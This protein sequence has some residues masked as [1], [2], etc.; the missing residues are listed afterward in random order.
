MGFRFR[1]GIV[2][3]S[4]LMLYSSASFAKGWGKTEKKL[5]QTANTEAQ[6]LLKASKEEVDWCTEDRNGLIQRRA[7]TLKE[8]GAFVDKMRDDEKL[9]YKKTRA[10]FSELR[11]RLTLCRSTILLRQVAITSL[12]IREKDPLEAGKGLQEAL[13]EWK[14]AGGEQIEKVVANSCVQVTKSLLAMDVPIDWQAIRAV[15]WRKR[16][17]QAG[18]LKLCPDYDRQTVFIAEATLDVIRVLQSNS[19]PHVAPQEA[20][21]ALKD[22]Y[23]HWPQGSLISQSEVKTFGANLSKM[24]LTRATEVVAAVEQSPSF[25][26][27]SEA[28]EVLGGARAGLGGTKT[29]RNLEVRLERAESALLKKRRDTLGP[30][31]SEETIGKHRRLALELEG[32]IVTRSGRHVMDVWKREID[33]GQQRLQSQRNERITRVMGPVRVELIG[34]SFQHGVRPGLSAAERARGLNVDEGR[35]QLEELAMHL[36]NDLGFKNVFV[37]LKG[38]DASTME[39]EKNA[40]FGVEVELTECVIED[41]WRPQ[42][43]ARRVS[44]GMGPIWDAMFL[45]QFVYPLHQAFDSLLLRVQIRN[46]NGRRFVIEKTGN[47]PIQAYLDGDFLNPSGDERTSAGQHGQLMSFLKFPYACFK[48]K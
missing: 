38:S 36:R 14:K 46:H 42:D 30:M 13:T 24:A 4:G 23:D 43:L 32:Q 10:K 47:K 9:T 28:F 3:V 41:L 21:A 20:A 40:L 19:G 34:K 33:V 16:V 1:L 8:V 22:L 31:N 35:A 7:A 37:T 48:Q 25:K 29:F 6:T 18:R 12:S 15:K 45:T 44:R 26:T 5:L 2:L 39:G 17:Q 11:R 27:I